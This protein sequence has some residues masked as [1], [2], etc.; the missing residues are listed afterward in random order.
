MSKK[1]K[2][3]VPLNYQV[4][5][6]DCVPVTFS[7]AV[8]FLIGETE[9]R[10]EIVD[11]IHDNTLDANG[12]RKIDKNGNTIGTLKRKTNQKNVITEKGYGG[13]T[14]KSIESLCRELGNFD[15]NGF[16]P[17]ECTY[18]KGSEITEKLIKDQLKHGSVG[19]VRVNLDNF[20]HYTM[21][22]DIKHNNVLMFDTYYKEELKNNQKTD[23]KMIQNHPLEFNRS[24]P[25]KH[26]FETEKD[27]YMMGDIKKREI[28][29]LKK[30]K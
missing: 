29:F 9:Y 15:E 1:A 19:I 28:V 8:N 11:I 21:M 12:Y 30:R 18:Q 10:S 25:L 24:V 2:D 6:F 5:E 27:D 22:T 4:G 23:V 14:K 20:G 13:T 26:L 16:E 3:S 7:N 17:L